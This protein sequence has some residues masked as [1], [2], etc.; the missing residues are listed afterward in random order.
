MNLLNKRKLLKLEKKNQ[1][2]KKLSE[3]IKKLIQ[4]IENADWKNPIEIKTIDLTLTM[5][6]LKVST[7]LI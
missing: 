2:N 1:G 7:S 4:D 6:I 5:F 3:A